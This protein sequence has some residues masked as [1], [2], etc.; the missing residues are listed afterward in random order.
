MGQILLVRHGQASLLAADYDR[1]SDMGWAQGRR[2]GAAL[3]AR[4]VVPLLVRTGGLRRQRD[5]AQALVQ[6]AGWALNPELDPDFDEYAYADLF[7]ATW[8]ELDSHAAVIAELRRQADPRGAFQRMFE[9]AFHAWTGGATA[10]GGLSWQAF[11]DR[12]TEAV[13]RVAQVC[14]SGR[15]A[16]VV[17]SGGVIAAV[18]QRLLHVP[19]AH[20]PVLH[21]PLRNAAI[22]RIQTR[23]AAIALAG[24]NEVAHLED[25]SG[26]SQLTYR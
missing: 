21:N 17:T 3:A 7:G 11:A 22:T 14:G 6:G 5:T 8:P 16:V 2:T 23:G 19:D 20:V 4:G 12:C 24:F 25:P 13:T 1:L 9:T 10:P 15:V 26:P 18:V